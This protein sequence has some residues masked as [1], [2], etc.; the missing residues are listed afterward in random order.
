MEKFFGMPVKLYLVRHGQSEGNEARKIFEETGDDN[1]FSEQF[2]RLHESQ[3]RLTPLGVNQAGV[4]GAWFIKNKLIDFD[5]MLV[6]DN[7]RAMETASHLDL[8]GAAWMI[9]HNLRERDGG[10][11]NGITL[12]KRDSLYIDQQKFYDEQ[13]F[14]F[15]PPQ[16]ES[17]AD[18]CTRVKIILDTL[19]RECNGQRVVIVC[20]GHV[21]RAFKIVLERM[22]L[23]EI[24]K[25]LLTKEDWG[26]VPNCAIVEY[27]RSNPYDYMEPIAPHFT[28]TRIIRPAGGG[29]PEDQFTFIKR[30]KY[31]NEELLKEAM[32]NYKN[33]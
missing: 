12:E 27:T 8:P 25:Y 28:Y 7:V 11:F 24:N 29:I 14:F 26:R 13:P 32:S 10:F 21:I 1:V 2:L 19:A 17:V 30:K 5:R 20:H 16:G 9:D 6:S 31:S 3:Y 15:R 33:L 4:C 22:P 23:S 18:L